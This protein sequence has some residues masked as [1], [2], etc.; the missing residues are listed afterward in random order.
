MQLPGGNFFCNWE[1]VY[2]FANE[3][4]LEEHLENVWRG[5]I[6]PQG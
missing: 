4:A 1:Y 6:S 5:D 2:G 3:E